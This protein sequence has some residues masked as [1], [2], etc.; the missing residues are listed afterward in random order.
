MGPRVVSPASAPALDEVR[1]YLAAYPAA[2]PL[3]VECSANPRMM[4]G[5]PTPR[6]PAGLAQKVARELVDRGVDCKRLVVVGWLDP[7]ADAPGEVVRFFV[8]GDEVRRPVGTEA[9]LDACASRE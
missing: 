9:R 3:R 4:S 6:W 2:G 1:A 5:M 7:A 8:G